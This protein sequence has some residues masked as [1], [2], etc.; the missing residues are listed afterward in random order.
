MMICVRYEYHLLPVNE[1]DTKYSDWV[2]LNEEEQGLF[3]VLDDLAV[4][5]E[6]SVVG[7]I[8]LDLDLLDVVFFL[9]DEGVDRVSG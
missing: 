9:S 1:S 3:G 6:G 8:L 7:K 4:Y 2:S 5:V